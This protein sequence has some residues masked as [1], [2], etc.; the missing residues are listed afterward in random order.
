VASTRKVRK[1]LAGELA[2][3]RGL[4]QSVD[5]SLSDVHA[6]ALALEIRQEAERCLQLLD[7]Y[8]SSVPGRLL[9]SADRKCQPLRD[10]LKRTEMLFRA[11]SGE[12]GRRG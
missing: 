10:E 7:Q 4:Q 3:L 1:E 6:K 9:S 2:K 8:Q 5:P 12:M 11:A